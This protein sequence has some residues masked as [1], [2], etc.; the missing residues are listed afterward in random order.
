MYEL[1]RYISNNLR[2]G[3]IVVVR[4]YTGDDKVQCEVI[5]VEYNYM[6]TEGRNKV[7][8]KAFDQDRNV[9]FDD[10]TGEEYFTIVMQ[11]IDL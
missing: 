2:P 6:G 4:D 8:V 7:L 5:R 11:Q 10:I 1:A 3:D 9:E